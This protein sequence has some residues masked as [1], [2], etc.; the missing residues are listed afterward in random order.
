LYANI[1]YKNKDF[2]GLISTITQHQPDIV[3]LVEYA[4][5]HDEVLAPL[6]KAEYP[7]V[8]R[9]VGGK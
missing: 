2:S 3:L 8:S 5:I 6:L 1:Y 4:K 7:Y 9:Y